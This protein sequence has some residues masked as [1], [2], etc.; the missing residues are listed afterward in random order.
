VAEKTVLVPEYEV[1]E[2]VEVDPKT[3]ALL[4]VDMQNDFVKEGWQTRRSDRKGHNPSNP[5]TFGYGS[6]KWHVGCLHPRHP[7]ARRP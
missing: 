6:P 1:A 2:K 4:I 7:F 3:T 5:Q